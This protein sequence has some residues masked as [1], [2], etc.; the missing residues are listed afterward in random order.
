V[1]GTQTRRGKP[2]SDRIGFNPSDGLGVVGTYSV[3][4]DNNASPKFQSLGWVGGGWD[5][6]NLVGKSAKYGFQSLGWVGDGWDFPGDVLKTF[7]GVVSIPRM[8]WGWLGRIS[9]YP[10]WIWSPRFQ[11]LGWGGGGWDFRKAQTLCAL[12]SKFQSL[13]WVGGGWD[14]SIP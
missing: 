2:V 8:G 1:V 11:S 4:A 10:R 7:F 3:E 5:G 14:F 12:G 9:F 6:A 13:G